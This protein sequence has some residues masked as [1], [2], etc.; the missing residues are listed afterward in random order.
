[1]A[2]ASGDASHPKARRPRDAAATS[3]V[4]LL[5]A[6]G[7]DPVDVDS[8]AGRCGVPAQEVAARLLE[9][10]LDGKVSSVAGGL[11]QRLA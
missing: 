10:E 4:P 8:L 3:V 11:F 1:M 2:R 5:Q 9:L 7:F 6:M